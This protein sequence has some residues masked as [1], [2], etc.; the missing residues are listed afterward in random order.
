MS[1]AHIRVRPVEIG[2]D[3][4]IAPV[5][6]C[7]IY[8]IVFT[9][10]TD[11][12]PGMLLT[13][14]AVAVVAGYG[15]LLQHILQGPGIAG[16]DRLAPDHGT[17]GALVHLGVEVIYG[18]A[19]ER[20]MD[21][22]FLIIIGACGAAH[23]TVRLSLQSSLGGRQVR[24][25]GI[26]DDLGLHDLPAV[27]DPSVVARI[28][29]EELGVVTVDGLEGVVQLILRACHRRREGRVEV[30][31]I[32]IY[33]SVEALAHIIQH[34]II[35]VVDSIKGQALTGIAHAGC[36]TQL[37]GAYGVHRLICPGQADI[38]ACLRALRGLHI[39][40][41]GPQIGYLEAV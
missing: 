28:H 35:R 22:F 9:V 38:S 36:F 4:L 32:G 30:H 5:V 15:Q 10:Q 2:I 16:T 19:R 27:G 21:V 11:Y 13:G 18:A 14:I 29:P 12:V 23:D 7:H 24:G 3:H 17:E 40:L 34:L 31:G 6:P 33:L 25:R 1:P 39:F 37:I 20:V 8:I 26:E 41:R